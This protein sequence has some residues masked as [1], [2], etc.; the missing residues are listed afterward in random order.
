MQDTGANLLASLL[1]RARAGRP[2]TILL[3]LTCLL[4]S[5]CDK[6]QRQA[7]ANRTKPV[8]SASPNPV[9]TGDFDQPLGS[10]RITWNTGS[11]MTGDLYV[12]VNR[13]PEVFLARGPTGSFDVKWI[14]FDSLYEF[15]LY[16]KKHS[17]L[18]ARVEVTRDD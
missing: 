9:P 5:A 3:S 17:R 12:K 6:A 10:T 8:L 14:Q 18:L 1:N 16:A 4:L 13:S 7:A 11:Q 2:I 15:R